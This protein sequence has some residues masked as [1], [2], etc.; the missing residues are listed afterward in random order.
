M[1]QP[2]CRPLDATDSL[3]SVPVLADCLRGNL[4]EPD[5]HAL[6]RHRGLR[7]DRDSER[8][9]DGNHL[10]L[11][12]RL[13]K[14]LLILGLLLGALPIHATT[15]TAPSCN[16]APG[17]L[18]VQKTVDHTSNGDTVIIPTGTCTWTTALTV[19]RKSITILGA[20]QT[21]TVIFD[22]ITTGGHQMLI[23]TAIPVSGS[24]TVPDFRLSTMSV[25]V[26]S[27]NNFNEMMDFT[28][29]CNPS[30]CSQIRI[31]NMI[32]GTTSTPIVPLGNQHYTLGIHN[33][34][35]VFDDN[36]VV[37]TGGGFFQIQLANYQNVGGFGDNSW[38]QP[39]TF[40]TAN[41]FYVET[42]TFNGNGAHI[43]VT[44]CEV[45]G[46]RSVF[47]FNTVID[48]NTG[49]HGTESSG[50]QRGIRQYEVFANRFTKAGSEPNLANATNLRS[51]VAYFFGNYMS[52]NGS[53]SYNSGIELNTFRVRH[54]LGGWGNCDGTGPWDKNDGATN[55]AHGSIKGISGNTYKTGET[56]T[57]DQFVSGNGVHYTF[58]DL[59]QKAV[60]DIVS[61]TTNSVTTA[62]NIPGA[63]NGDVYYI[64]GTTS[65]YSGKFTGT[66]GS[67]T[68]TDSN[69][70]GG[71]GWSKN[72]WAPSCPGSNCGSPYSVRDTS[73]G[74]GSEILSNTGTTI[75]LML[76][77]GFNQPNRFT[78]G[79]NYEI[80]RSTV[81]I[82]MT[83]Y[84]QSSSMANQNPLLTAGWVNNM[85][86]PVYEWGDTFQ[87]PA[88]P[89]NSS[90]SAN[91]AMT[92][93]VIAN[94]DF[95][96]GTVNQGPQ[97]TSSSPFDGTSGT[98]YGILS[99]RPNTCRQGTAY[100]A[101]DQGSWNVSSP[102]VSFPSQA[103]GGSSVSQGVLYICG[104]S[105]W[106]PNPSY[107]PYTYP[108]TL[109][110][111]AQA[112]RR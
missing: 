36:S 24:Y 87:Q 12:V 101:T 89:V 98:G 8:I 28:G 96:A 38:A 75:S 81:C 25:F 108:H 37:Q 100:F 50:R 85:Q 40:G 91:E 22:N 109:T 99:L 56:F 6:H 72:Q 39:D 41:A 2:A 110:T 49:G 103:F 31:D 4:F 77:G 13:M 84:G 3:L 62:E 58:V 43:F 104:A 19:S 17:Q 45:P 33:A 46:C 79:D 7:G 16:N 48:G 88:P 107:V 52:G 35:G 102:I 27:G 26:T 112:L 73:Q 82:D 55:P 51:G 93:R 30:T 32:W 29:T 54:N 34:F 95:Y 86:E 20:S 71:T 44:G 21:D 1:A 69:A 60:A 5:A 63:A 90:P 18:D 76:S 74:W 57:V 64:F 65:Y 83:G 66:T 61:N 80:L 68:L 111:V 47:R 67:A 9:A 70:N 23:V 14:H 105:G 78:S 94:R 15:Y 59:Q 92:A 53:P 10:L 11:S 97:K 106:P 42:N